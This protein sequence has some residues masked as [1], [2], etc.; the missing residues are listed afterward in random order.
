[1][2]ILQVAA[3]RSAA[4]VAYSGGPR[5]CFPIAAV[6][7]RQSCVSTSKPEAE[8]VALAHGLRVVGYPAMHVWDQV[9][10]GCALSLHE[11]NSTARSVI[12]PGKNQT[13]RHLSR[14]HGINVSWLAEQYHEGK[15]RMVQTP[16][17]KMRADIFTKSFPSADLF[18]GACQLV[19]ICSASQVSELCFREEEPPP[20]QGGDVRRAG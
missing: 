6:S 13:M 15:Y 1:M 2:Q 8:L 5:L 20:V 10:L 14:T 7:K 9:L 12:L 19:N 17:C 16:S 11:D 18:D 4:Q 3:T